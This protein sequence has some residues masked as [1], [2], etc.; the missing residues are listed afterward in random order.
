VAVPLFFA[1]LHDIK[2]EVCKLIVLPE[3]PSPT[4]EEL[5]NKG[6]GDE[7]RRRG[8]EFHSWAKYLR[9]TF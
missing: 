3:F 1:S 9:E 5:Q 4:G 8:G 6:E 2:K 7:R